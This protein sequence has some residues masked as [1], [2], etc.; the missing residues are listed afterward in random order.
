[1]TPLTVDPTIVVLVN[2]NKEV[3][4]IATNIAPDVKV[5]VARNRARFDS[6]ACNMPFVQVDLSED[7][8][9]QES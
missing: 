1:M 6:V 5:L 7:Y 8:P 2:E 3:V 4:G 9:V